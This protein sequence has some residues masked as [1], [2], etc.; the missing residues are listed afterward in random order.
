MVNSTIN[1]GNQNFENLR[2]TLLDQYHSQTIMH[3]GYILALTVGMLTIISNFNAFFERGLLTIIIFFIIFGFVVGVG[4]F[5]SCRLFYWTYLA[6]GIL[7]LTE[8]GFKEVC[9]EK[10]ME[11]SC[12]LKMQNFIIDDLKLKLRAKAKP[13]QFRL[14]NLAI[15]SIEKIICYVVI[16]ILITMGVSLAFYFL[17][18]FL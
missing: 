17:S 8:E 5:F 10:K 7:G 2:K 4:F 14:A 13:I 18:I 9:K 12:V 3:A 16:V 15:S 11:G 6:N 1:Y